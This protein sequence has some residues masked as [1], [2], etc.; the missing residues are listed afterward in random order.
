M[1]LYTPLHDR[2]ARYCSNHAY[3]IMDAEDLVQET[4][5][6]TLQRFHTI[7]EPEKLFGYMISVANNIVRDHLR[8]KKF[9][10]DY[11][12]KAFRRLESRSTDPETAMDIHHL[13]LAL[14]QLPVRDKEAILMFEI[15]GFSIEE[16]A[17]VQ[18]SGTNATK[19]RLSRAREKLRI[20]MGDVSTPLDAPKGK[21][22]KLFT[23]L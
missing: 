20:L 17:A 10:G 13:H 4:I 8:R 16:I 5:L 6:A 9:T 18:N 11:N 19:T 7:R 3:G 21:S 1:R 15:S 2:F 22:V 12:E 23:L 14:Q